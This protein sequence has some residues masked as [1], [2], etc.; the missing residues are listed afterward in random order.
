[1]EDAQK[2][3]HINMLDLILR[4]AMLTLTLLDGSTLLSLF[5][6]RLRN[7]PDIGS[8]CCW[9]SAIHCIESW[10]RTQERWD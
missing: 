10:C 2:F 4:V 8:G 3:M 5:N 9:R 7:L 6:H 1:M